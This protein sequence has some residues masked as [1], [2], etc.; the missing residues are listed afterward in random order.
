[1]TTLALR[2]LGDGKF[3]ASSRA[4]AFRCETLAMNEPSIW[5][6][7]E[8]RSMKSHEHF[9][10]IVDD[11]WANLPEVLSQEFP[12]PEHL[13]KWAL[14]KAGYCTT[15]KVACATNQDAIKLVNQA[16]AMDTFAVC[17]LVGNV[18]TIA[19]AESQSVRAMCGERF[20]KSKEKVLDVL[21][22]MLGADASK[23]GRAA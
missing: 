14:I 6:K 4:M 19:R 11:A 16:A 15:V 9:F 5:K 2:Y 12:S 8:P 18:V 13:R 7:V 21:S 22:Q 17:E 3:I 23:A 10:A 1:M 20:Q